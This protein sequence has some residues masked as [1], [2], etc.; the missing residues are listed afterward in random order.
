M[1]RFKSEN[2]QAKIITGWGNNNIGAQGIVLKVNNSSSNITYVIQK[3][4][5]GTAAMTAVRPIAGIWQ[6]LVLIAIGNRLVFYTN[7]I[8]NLDQTVGTSIQASTSLFLGGRAG[9]QSCDMQMAEFKFYGRSPTAEEV[10]LDYQV[11][12]GGLWQREPTRYK[13]YF[14]QGLNLPNRRRSSRFLGFPG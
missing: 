8:L 9:N 7:G 2:N 12:P 3:N 4:Q 11:G 1:T 13:S 6:H 5:G 10:R 14:A